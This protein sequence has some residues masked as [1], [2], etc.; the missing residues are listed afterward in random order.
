VVVAPVATP[1]TVSSADGIVTLTYSSPLSPTTDIYDG[2]VHLANVD[3]TLH[4]D[5][6]TYHVP[7]YSQDGTIMISRDTN[8]TGIECN[9][10]PEQGMKIASGFKE[11]GG[12]QWEFASYSGT[13]MG[14]N[15]D[16]TSYRL[17]MPDN[18]CYDVSTLVHTSS[19]YNDVDQN[20]INASTQAL[21]SLLDQA[22]QTI[23]VKI[24]P[25]K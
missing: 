2:I 18:T 23:S 15:Y 22:V 3:A 19:D 11:L 14:S 6:S 5:F 17:F 24:V 13:G 10:F 12:V 21:A 8:L 25:L 16:S 9:A 20:A 4:T 7:N 1:T